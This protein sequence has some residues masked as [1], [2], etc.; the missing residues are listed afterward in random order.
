MYRI[1][2]SDSVASK[3]TPAALGT[4]GYF[5]DGVAAG[6][7]GTVVDA[8]FMNMVQEVI[9]AVLDDQSIAHSKTDVTTL[10]QA[11]AAKIANEAPPEVQ[12]TTTVSGVAETATDAEAQAGTAA[13]KM[14]TP[15]NLGSQ[16]GGTGQDGYFRII[17]TPFLVQFVVAIAQPAGATATWATSFASTTYTVSWAVALNTP[18]DHGDKPFIEIVDV[19]TVAFHNFGNDEPVHLIAIGVAP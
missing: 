15:D 17:G 19:D 10:V 12:A 5:K 7:D 3:P 2:T 16:F 8:D 18:Q 9:I 13:D 14:V 4:E 1:D 11:I 6:A